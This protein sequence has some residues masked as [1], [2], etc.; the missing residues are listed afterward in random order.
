MTKKLNPL[1]QQIKDAQAEVAKW[2][3]WMKDSCVLQ[4]LDPYYERTQAYLKEKAFQEEQARR[5]RS[6]PTP[7]IRKPH[8]K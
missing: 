1:L 6:S 3:Q 5:E 2:P 4:G 8:G 7:L